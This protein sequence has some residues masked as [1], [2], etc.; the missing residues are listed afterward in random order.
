MVC[1]WH[2]EKCPTTS[3]HHGIPR[4]RNG[5]GKHVIC[6]EIHR[7]YHAL[8]GNKTPEEVLDFLADYIWNGQTDLALDWVKK[9]GRRKRVS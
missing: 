4:S 5:K 9:R 2:G 8:F 6:D 3:N 7:K 1:P